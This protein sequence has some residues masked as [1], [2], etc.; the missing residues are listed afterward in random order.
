[1]VLKKTLQ[2]INKSKGGYFNMLVKYSIISADNQTT[3]I[4]SQAWK[5]NKIKVYCYNRGYFIYKETI[6]IIKRF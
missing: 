5:D 2:N 4:S 6:K 3:L 1:V